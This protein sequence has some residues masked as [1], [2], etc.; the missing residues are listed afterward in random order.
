MLARVYS[1]GQ[2]LVIALPGFMLARVRTPL[3]WSERE[4]KRERKRE[5]ERKSKRESETERK[6]EGERKRERGRER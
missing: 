3:H 4:I 5:G 2:N 1:Y 6:R